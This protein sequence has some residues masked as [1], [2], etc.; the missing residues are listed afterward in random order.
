MGVKASRGSETRSSLGTT[1]PS[2]WRIQHSRFSRE[3]LLIGRTQEHFMGTQARQICN[4]KITRE[5][6]IPSA[7]FG[8]VSYGHDLNTVLHDMMQQQQPR[9]PRFLRSDR[10]LVMAL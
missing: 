2:N 8:H 6:I 3:E 9:R 5:S 7:K 10:D 4:G 1:N